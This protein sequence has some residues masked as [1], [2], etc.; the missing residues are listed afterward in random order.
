MRLQH[1]QSQGLADI[2]NEHV[3]TE[4]SQEIG[5]GSYYLSWICT[6]Y[7]SFTCILLMKLKLYIFQMQQGQGPQREPD[8]V[9]R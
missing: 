6:L 7:Q 5:N 9:I 8:G 2:D 1:T 3:A 4:P